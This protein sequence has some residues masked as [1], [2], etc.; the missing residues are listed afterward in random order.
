M[1]TKTQAF[2]FIISGGLSAI[3]DLGLTWV[4]NYLLGVAVPV[5]RTVGFIVGTITAY[6]IN[7]RWTFQAEGSAR[8]FGQ[9]MV[10]YAITYFVNVGGQTLLQGL[11]RD[12]GLSH[13]IALVAAF[14]ISQ[15][16]ATVINFVV[17][18]LFIFKA[19]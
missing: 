12:W 16:T 7:R 18:K 2:R 5:A 4:L 10:L 13:Q 19:A 15:G 17:Q 14:V 3:P 9:V 11:F 6:M 8:R 1:Q